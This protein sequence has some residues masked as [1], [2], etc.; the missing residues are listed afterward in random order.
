MKTGTLLTLV[1]P[2]AIRRYKITQKEEY[3]LCYVTSLT[4][5]EINSFVCTF[6]LLPEN[7]FKKYLR[8][9]KTTSH[10]QNV[11]NIMTSYK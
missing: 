11:S 8:K 4:H 3:R 9:E 2:S 6:M 7:R 1:R 5:V 10:R